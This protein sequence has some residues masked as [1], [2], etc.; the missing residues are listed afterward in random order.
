MN[1]KYDEGFCFVNI[2][3]RVRGKHYAKWKEVSEIK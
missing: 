1:L 2:P 3:N